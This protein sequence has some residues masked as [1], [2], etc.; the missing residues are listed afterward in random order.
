MLFKNNGN[1]LFLI[2]IAVALFAALSYAVTR[3]GEGGS[4]IEKE[5]LSLAV[6]DVMSYM[7]LM[8]HTIQKMM[9]RGV[10]FENLDFN[11]TQRKGVD[12]STVPRDNFKCTDP[13]CEIF[14]PEG[15]GLTFRN[16]P[17][18]AQSDP[19]P[20][21]YGSS[22]L[23]PGEVEAWLVP[24]SGLGTSAP[25]LLVLISAVQEDVCKAYNRRLGLPELITTSAS[26]REIFHQNSTDHA[27]HHTYTGD[28]A[29]Q[30]SFCARRPSDSVPFYNLFH[31]AV[32]R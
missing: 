25:E 21:G 13:S 19:L 27:G 29:G 30:T 32:I 10:P 5:K 16:F 2:L 11:S 4:G 12:G 15:G 28:V 20:D 26:S 18:I 3:S 8:E 1:A 31:V 9:I 14:S 7:G 6:S 24:I 23:R 22:W 17:E